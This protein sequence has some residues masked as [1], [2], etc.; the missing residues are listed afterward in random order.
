MRAGEGLTGDGVAG[1]ALK[2]CASKEATAGDERPPGPAQPQSRLTSGTVSVLP[3]EG[4]A[5]GVAS[6]SQIFPTVVV[7][8][9]TP[10]TSLLLVVLF[11]A[12]PASS[13]GVL[14]IGPSP[15]GSL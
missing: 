8:K 1:V 9:I 6:I 11:F 10:P 7:R 12:L 15:M 2:P 14:T 3:G 5:N 13:A 4:S